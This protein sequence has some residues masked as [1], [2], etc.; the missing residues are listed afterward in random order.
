MNG[1]KLSF[2]LGST[3]LREG[4]AEPHPSRLLIPKFTIKLR[5]RRALWAAKGFVVVA[6]TVAPKI[7]RYVAR[8][9]IDDNQP[10][11]R[12]PLADGESPVTP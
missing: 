12:A 9:K 10:V 2:P 4:A 5:L 8:V 1:K 3:L 6:T 7:A 11:R